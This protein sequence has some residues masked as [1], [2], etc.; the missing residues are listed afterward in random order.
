[1]KKR[2]I[3]IAAVIVIAVITVL[4]LAPRIIGKKPFKNIQASDI[5]A[6]TAHLYPPDTVIQIDDLDT[7]AGLLR[8]LVIYQRKEPSYPPPAGGEVVFTLY[9]SDGSQMEIS[10]DNTFLEIDGVSYRVKYAPSEALQSFAYGLLYQQ[11]TNN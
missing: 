2:L 5:D 8:E 1:M 9:L 10:E 3:V 7:F 11:Q 4:L 6:A